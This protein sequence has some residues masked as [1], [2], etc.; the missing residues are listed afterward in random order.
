MASNPNNCGAKSIQDQLERILSSVAFPGSPRHRR[1]LD[2]VVSETLAGRSDRI[3]AY[4]I[5]TTVFE[6]PTEFDPQTDPVVRLEAI[7]LRRALAHYYLTEGKHGPIRISIPKGSYI[8]EFETL[9]A[10]SPHPVDEST[11][12]ISAGVDDV[13]RREVRIFIPRES[14]SAGSGRW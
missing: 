2:Y 4:T 8:P 11:S 14:M 5:A 1:F 13:I 10:P 7:R 9:S 12:Y 3:K 6:R